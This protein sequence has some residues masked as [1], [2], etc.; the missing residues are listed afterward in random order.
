MPRLS[1]FSIVAVLLLL[2][3]YFLAPQQLPLV[4]YKLSLV[5]LAAV[6]GY[7]LDRHLFPYHRIRRDMDAGI[8]EP[9]MIRRAVIVGATMVAFALAL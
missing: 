5:T 3:L 2:A 4:V 8:M 1:F 9:R 6:L 7:W